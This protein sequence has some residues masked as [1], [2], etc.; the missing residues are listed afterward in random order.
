MTDC[1]RPVAAIGV[2]SVTLSLIGLYLSDR[3]GIKTG[4]RGELPGSMVLIAVASGIL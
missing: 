3:L 2:V 4:E 1:P